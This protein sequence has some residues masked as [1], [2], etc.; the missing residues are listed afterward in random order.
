[1]KSDWTAPPTDADVY[2]VYSLEEA[3]R[4]SKASTRKAKGDSDVTVTDV[5]PLAEYYLGHKLVLSHRRQRAI[6]TGYTAST[7]TIT[8]EW[9]EDLDSPWVDVVGCLLTALWA[10]FL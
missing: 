9:I 8:F 2:L 4:L 1:M 10:I 7:K 5:T 6:V 3:K